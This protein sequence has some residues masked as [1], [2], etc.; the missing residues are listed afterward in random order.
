MPIPQKTLESIL[1]NHFPE[2]EITIVDLAGDDDHYSVTIKDKS[3]NGKSRIEQHKI[4]NNALK[5]EL[6]SGVLHAMQLKTAAL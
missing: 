6:M 3:F 1:K 4:V 5:S 2:A